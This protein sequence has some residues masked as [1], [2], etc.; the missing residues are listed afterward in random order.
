MAKVLIV[1]DGPAG[2][3]AALFLAKN[4]HEVTVFGQNETAMH[5]AK[6]YNYLGILQITG[7]EFQRI[8]K[9][10][11]SS[12]GAELIDVEVKSVARTDGGFTVT[13]AEDETREGDYLVLAAGA[14]KPFADSLGLGENSA[15]GVA[16]DREGRTEIKG[17]YYVGWASRPKRTQAIISA[18]EGAAAALSILSEEQGKDFHDFDTPE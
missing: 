6:L 10:Q 5:Y 13:T 11:V 9:A 3:S 7:T 18:G 1:G 15:G 4:G 12:F 2:L 8:A 14:S 16:I 17:L